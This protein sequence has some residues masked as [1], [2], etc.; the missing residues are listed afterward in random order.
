MS[1]NAHYFLMQ[2][3]HSSSKMLKAPEKLTIKGNALFQRASTL[4]RDALRP[5]AECKQPGC[6]GTLKMKTPRWL[7]VGHVCAL[8]PKTKIKK[9]AVVSITNDTTAPTSTRS[10]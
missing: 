5:M 7:K 10:L 1:N 9:K 6:V 8:P 4:M 3:E 2:G